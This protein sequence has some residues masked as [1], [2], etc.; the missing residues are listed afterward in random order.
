MTAGGEG[1]FTPWFILEWGR[2]WRDYRAAVF[3]ML[4]VKSWA[5]L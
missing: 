3:T 2:I 1:N 5:S 4:G